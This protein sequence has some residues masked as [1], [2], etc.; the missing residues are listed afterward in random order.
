MTRT[1]PLS[2]IIAAIVLPLAFAAAEQPPPGQDATDRERTHVE[3]ITGSRYGYAVSMGGLFDGDMTRDPIGYAAFNQY[4]EPNRSVLLENTGNVPVKN[5]W[6][7]VDGKHD[8][9]TVQRILESAL[10]P[11]MTDRDKALALW[12]QEVNSRFHVLDG[13]V[14]FRVGHGPLG[15]VAGER[16]R[17]RHRPNGDLGVGHAL[18]LR[19]SIHDAAR[20]GEALGSGWRRDHGASAATTAA[21]RKESRQEEVQERPRRSGRVPHTHAY[22]PQYCRT[23]ERW[24]PDLALPQ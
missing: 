15:S 24:P 23:P 5:P 18:L 16:R 1:P 14:A 10:K 7:L 9:R 21:T 2:W 4:F 19:A 8:W 3:T 11:G 6:V 13:V 20:D 17:L 22:T 12:W